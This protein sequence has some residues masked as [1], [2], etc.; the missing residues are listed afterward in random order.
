MANK[1][2]IMDAMSKAIKEFGGKD[3]TKIGLE[4]IYNEW[5]KQ[6]SD[7]RSLLSKHPLWNEEAQAIVYSTDVERPVNH[8][9][10]ENNMIELLKFWWT[11]KKE[12]TGDP[13]LDS[14]VFN[15]VIALKDSFGFSTG[16]LDES[17]LDYYKSLMTE[18]GFPELADEFRS[19]KKESKVLGKILTA[20][21]LPEYLGKIDNGH[22][23][24]VFAYDKYFAAIADSL[25]PL[26]V[27]RHTLLS[28]HPA[29]YLLMSHG[30]GWKS[31]HN[32]YDGGWQAGTLSYMLDG[33]SAILYTVDEKYTGKTFW[34]E[35]KINRQMY[36][37]KEGTLIGSR[38]YPKPDDIELA[39]KFRTVVQSMIA[40]CEE[41]DNYWDTYETTSSTGRMYWETYKNAYHYPDY[42]YENY[43]AKLSLLRSANHPVLTIGAPS[44]SVT[45]GLPV[46]RSNTIV[47]DYRVCAHCGQIVDSSNLLHDY[48]TGKD[49]CTD[50][51]AACAQCG[52]I[53][54][55]F[56][57]GEDTEI[58]GVHLCSSC[59]KTHIKK[60]ACCGKPHYTEKLRTL[61]GSRRRMICKDCASDASKG[62][63]SCGRCHRI[64]DNTYIMV[65][66]DFNGRKHH[67][68]KLCMDNFISDFSIE[69]DF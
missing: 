67:V 37:I 23:R 60:C 54:L 1:T 3:A 19:G 27:K 28:I 41:L 63:A 6:K 40:K 44:L 2:E 47:G 12:V 46:N 14:N 42:A 25:N 68:C 66:S 13:F 49:Y 38:I 9:E 20:W 16:T 51:A 55:K 18:N 64:G 17:S 24:E 65:M 53:I 26:T 33:V 58:D 62:Y 34:Y 69:G 11:K 15:V 22:G 61:N 39:T 35:E 32:I 5:D 45:V 59:A 50:C 36:M 31:C 30:T 10:F 8:S 4:A 57:D 52:A 7:L 56:I 43:H 21:G 48:N 29:D